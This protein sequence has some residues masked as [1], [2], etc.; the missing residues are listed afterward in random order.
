MRLRTTFW[1]LTLFTVWIG[2]PLL[3]QQ[4]QEGDLMQLDL[5]QSG[6]KATVTVPQGSEIVPFVDPS[7]MIQGKDEK[8]RL[9]ISPDPVVFDDFYLNLVEGQK[10]DVIT[11]NK[12]ITKEP[13]LMLYEHSFF[14]ETSYSFKMNVTLEDQKMSCLNDQNQSYSRIHVDQMIAACQSLKTK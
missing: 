6:L 3:A 10:G 13:D 5:G 1:G 11:F 8:F 2:A 9:I 4:P 12:W 7:I 14:K